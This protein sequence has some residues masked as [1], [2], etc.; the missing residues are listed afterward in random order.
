ML[1]PIPTPPVTTT[2]PV[3]ALVLLV[4][5]DATTLPVLKVPNVRVLSLQFILPVAA[6]GSDVSVSNSVH[7]PSLWF[8]AIPV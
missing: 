6:F 3:V 1:P 7:T 2:P 8:L 4:L 5:P